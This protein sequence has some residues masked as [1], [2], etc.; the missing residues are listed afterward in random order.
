MKNIVTNKDLD[1]I[2]LLSENARAKIR[3]IAAAVRKSPQRVK[4][5]LGTLQREKIMYSPYSIIDYSYFGLLLFRVYFKG[6]YIGEQ[7]KEKIMDFFKKHA[8]VVSLYE[9]SGEFDLVAELCTPNP[10]RFYKELK[11]ITTQ[12]P[13]LNNYKIVLNVVTHIYPRWY[14]SKGKLL[15]KEQ[16]VSIVVGGDRSRESFDGRELRVLQT[17]VEQPTVRFT[18]LAE[19]T[20]LNI[21]TAISLL[22]ALYKRKVVRGFQYLLDLQQLGVGKVRLFLKLHN[23]S[24]EREDQLMQYL[25][26]TPE[27]VQVN[28]TVGDWNLEVDIESPDYLQSRL[29]IRQ[30]RETFKDLI[31]TFNMM[32]WYYA[33]QKS[34]LPHYLF[35]EEGKNGA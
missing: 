33:Y 30:L 18:M 1:L 34:Y 8:F 16:A 6:G 19:K 31:E 12:F 15:L 17:I 22:K 9:L 21:K 13:T 23:L 14:L 11:K 25:L 26:N 27:I 35:E 3:T 2:F 24:E 5:T 29:L 10:S 32:E 20:G 28:K 4:Y 7:E